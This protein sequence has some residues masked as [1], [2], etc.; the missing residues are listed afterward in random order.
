MGLYFQCYQE[1]P[2]KS[3]FRPA[4]SFGGDNDRPLHERIRPITDSD[5]S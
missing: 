5:L 1:V 2:P 3:E 4:R